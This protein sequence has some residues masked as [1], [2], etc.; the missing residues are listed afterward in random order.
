MQQRTQLPPTLIQKLQPH[1]P[2]LD[3]TQVRVSLCLPWYV[4]WFAP[5]RAA[6]FTASARC[7]CCIPAAYAP[8]TEAGIALLAHE[9]THCVQYHRHGCWGM[10]LRY[11]TQ[12]LRILA[13][14]R[15]LQRAYWEMPLEVE[16]RERAAAVRERLSL[17]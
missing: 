4:R 15:H 11:I 6:A 2:E 9:L 12:Y 17:G 8:E 10:R 14:T 7:V 5:I 16:A 13:T 3:L 1:F